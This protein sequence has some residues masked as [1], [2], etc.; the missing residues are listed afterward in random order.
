MYRKRVPSTLLL[1]AIAAFVLLTTGCRLGELARRIE[2]VRTITP[3][4]VIVTEAREVRGFT[5]LDIRTLGKV[6]LTQGDSE[7]LTVSGSDNLVALVT[8]RVSQGTLIVETEENV[9]WSNSNDEDGLTFD[10]TVKDL[11][12]LTVSG[13]ANVDM[14]ALTTSTLDV[15]MSGAG[16]FKLNDLSADNITIT[17][18]GLGNVEIAGQ[19][20]GQR[21]TISGAGDVKNANLQCET[22]D[23]TVPGLGTATIWVTDK[24]T[25][26]IS[27]S[28]SVRYYGSPEV[29]TETKGLG[30]FEALGNK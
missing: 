14:G 7:S 4:G 5:A 12:G 24:L 19:V 8:V 3:S 23:V 1:L 2:S 18:S 15:T 27:G 22:A 25:G 21:I 28:G 29:D 26:E 17:V 10:I 9:A 6:I 30:S 13:L 11:S 20:A 16:S